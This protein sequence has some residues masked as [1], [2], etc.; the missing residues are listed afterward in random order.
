M[1]R[2]LRFLLATASGLLLYR[3]SPGPGH[4]DWLAWIALTP[5]LL[6]LRCPAVPPGRPPGRLETAA[7]GFACGLSFYLPLLD[8]ISTVL[9]THGGLSSPAALGAAVLLAAYM[10]IYPALFA[11]LA[12]G[13]PLLAAP[14]P[15][16]ALDG[17]RAVLFSGFPWM[18]LG[19][20]LFNRPALLQVAAIAG[21]HGLTFAIV[22][23]NSLVTAT[24]LHL[25][26]PASSCR[27]QPPPV[28]QVAVATILLATTLALA[29]WQ[30]HRLAGDRQLP[31]PDRLLVAGI[32]QGNIDQDQKWRPAGMARAID[33]HLDLTARLTRAPAW[34]SAAPRLVVWPETSLP[35][36]PGR[37]DGFPDRLAALLAP[38]GTMLLTGVPWEAPGPVYTNR[39]I[40]VAPDG[41][42]TGHYDKQHLVPFGEYIPLRSILPISSPVVQTMADFTPGPGGQGALACGTARIGVLICFESIF[43]ELAR[44]SV[45]QGS[46]LLVNI[47]NDAWF[48]RSNAPY[49]HFAMA[50]LR[51]VENRRTLLRAANTG[52]SGVIDPL[53]RI[54]QRTGIF[55][56]ATLLAT[57]ER[58][59]DRTLYTR[60]GHW[61]ASGCLATTILLLLLRT[62]RLNIRATS[63]IIIRWRLPSR[64]TFRPAGDGR[65]RPATRSPGAAF[66]AAPSGRRPP[67]QHHQRP[68]PR[69][70]P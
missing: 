43:P 24:I 66:P 58:R 21:H 51:A 22:L 56:P 11:M 6:A 49:Q 65:G 30:Y 68:Q 55:Q 31:A 50:V 62:G 53:G 69:A 63:A 8:W 47:T 38:T 36:P 48:G 67:R 54:R 33:R 29:A 3:A 52:I 57:V 32:V 42:I 2:P 59:T 34:T 37:L 7:M 46:D 14:L 26:R 13:L 17:L 16:V 27:P 15:W 18:D 61:F 19:Y 44:Q 45:R 9:A 70:G 10:A 64:R 41:R 23:A 5:L 40:L 20:D 12:A 35:A 60:G 4:A 1:S 28:R 25:S 39:A